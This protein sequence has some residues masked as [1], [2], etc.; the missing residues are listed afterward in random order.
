MKAS[1]EFVEAIV[2]EVNPLWLPNKDGTGKVF[3]SRMECY[4]YFM[5]KCYEVAPKGYMDMYVILV[6]LYGWKFS[7]AESFYKLNMESVM[8]NR[9]VMLNLGDNGSKMFYRNF[10]TCLHNYYKNEFQIA[11][12][13]AAWNFHK[14]NT[15]STTIKA[16]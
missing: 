11:P 12:F 16:P 7:K 4:I 6:R 3:R 10:I 9:I 15:L 13:E 1:R 2:N 5:D 8:G 14:A